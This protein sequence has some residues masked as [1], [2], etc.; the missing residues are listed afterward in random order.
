MEIFY[1][2]HS[3]HPLDP[4][5]LLPYFQAFIRTRTLKSIFPIQKKF[6]FKVHSRNPKIIQTSKSSKLH[7][8]LE[9][10]EE[11][12]HTPRAEEEWVLNAE[13]SNNECECML[14]EMKAGKICIFRRKVEHFA[15]MVH[16]YELHFSYQAKGEEKK[17]FQFLLVYL[18]LFVVLRL[19]R[20]EC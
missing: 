15:Q 1:I 6:F 14:K 16:F 3:L 5:S 10:Y 7:F 18:E 9:L 12:V 17:A 2:L 13:W 19:E 20:Y 8:I 11:N 4:F